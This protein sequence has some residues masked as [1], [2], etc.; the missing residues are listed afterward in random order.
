MA[1][2]R[3]RGRGRLR[4]GVA[5]AVLGSGVTAGVLLRRRRPRPLSSK[6]PQRTF[7][8]LALRGLQR[9]KKTKMGYRAL[10]RILASPQVRKAILNAI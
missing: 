8:G 2:V 3:Q 9:V 1:R 6:P 4:Y 5:G 10:D 7:A